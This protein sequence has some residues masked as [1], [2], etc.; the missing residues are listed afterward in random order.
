V[1]H[2]LANSEPSAI[3]GILELKVQILEFVTLEANELGIDLADSFLERFL[4]GPADSHD[5]SNRLHSAA[6]VALYVLELG[7]IPSRDFGDDIVKRRLEVGSSG[8]CHDIGELRQA[9]PKTDLGP[10]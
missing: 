8:L 2:G 4:E 6:N 3:R 10:A 1:K 9:V 5:L 7:K